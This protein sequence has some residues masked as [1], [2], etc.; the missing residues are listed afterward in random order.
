MTF[1]VVEIAKPTEPLLETASLNEALAV[2]AKHPER[3]ILRGKRSPRFIPIANASFD[4]KD[5]R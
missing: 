2:C 3:G 4:P 5:W 1:T